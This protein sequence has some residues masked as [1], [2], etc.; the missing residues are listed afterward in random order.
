MLKS[1][2]FPS[3]C[4]FE[5]IWFVLSTEETSVQYSFKTPMYG[6]SCIMTFL[7]V[8]ADANCPTSSICKCS[9]VEIRADGVCIPELLKAILKLFPLDTS[10]DSAAVMDLVQSDKFKGL[11]V[12]VWD[13]YSDLLKQA[14]SDGNFKFVDR[15]AFYERANKS[16][17]VVA[18]G[19]TALYGNLII[20]KGVI[21]PGEQC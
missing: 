18:T 10:D 16:F 13:Q 14:G 7:F 19:E 15:F 4:S 8:L 3:V 9:P 20:K 21:P 5:W 12:P 6:L 1:V 2:D 11:K 17:A